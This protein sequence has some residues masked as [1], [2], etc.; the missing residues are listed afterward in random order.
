ML[1]ALPAAAWLGGSGAGGGGSS[2]TTVVPKV[3]HILGR[4]ALL[5]PATAEKFSSMHNEPVLKRIFFIT[6]FTSFT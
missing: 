4:W 6:M 5:A 3:R 2:L 1:P